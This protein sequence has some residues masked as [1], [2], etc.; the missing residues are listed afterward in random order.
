MLST[1]NN[2]IN[3]GCHTTSRWAKKCGYICRR[4]LTGPDHKLF[5]LRYGPYTITKAIGKNAFEL[6]IPPFLG[7]HPIFNV[8]CLCPYFPPLPDTS[9][10]EEQLTPTELNPECMEQA[11]KD[12][13]M[14]IQI[15][16][17]Y[18]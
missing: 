9:D 3:I 12:C 11:T 1:S 5:P 13:I 10:I 14:Q 16:N 6:N 18:Q 7:L 15:K 4:S 2:M 8:D 17:T